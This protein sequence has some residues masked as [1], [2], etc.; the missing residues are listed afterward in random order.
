M[1][2]KRRKPHGLRQRQ[3]FQERQTPASA[4]RQTPLPCGGTD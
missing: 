2:G 4:E 1:V 3:Y